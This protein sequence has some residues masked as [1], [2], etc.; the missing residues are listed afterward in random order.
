ML[1]LRD[2]PIEPGDIIFVVHVSSKDPLSLLKRLIQSLIN[3]KQS[4]HGHYEVASVFVCSGKNKYGP[5]CYNHEK[6]L[7]LSSNT[8][9]SKLNLLSVEQLIDILINHWSKK[10][11]PSE[12]IDYLKQSEGWPSSLVNQCES[13]QSSE[14]LMQTLINECGEDKEKIL[15]LLHCF[16]M[17]S[18]YSEIL[19]SVKSSLLVFKPSISIRNQF[20]EKYAY[21]AEITDNYVKKKQSR[22]SIWMVI[23]SIFQ[24]AKQDAIDKSPHPPSEITYCAR[25]VIEVLNQIDPNLVDRGRHVTPKTL[26]AGLREATRPKMAR[27]DSNHDLDDFEAQ[28]AQAQ[29]LIPNFSLVIIPAAGKDLMQ[30]FILKID[31]EI[32]RIENKRRKNSQ[33]IQKLKDIKDIV[34]SYR[35]D[36]YKAYPITLQVT[37]AMELMAKLQPVLQRKTGFLGSWYPAT[38]YQNIRSFLRGQGIFDGDIREAAEHLKTIPAMTNTKLTQTEPKAEN[39]ELAKLTYIFSDWSFTQWSEEKQK[40]MIEYMIQRLDSGCSVLFWEHGQLIAKTKN[41]LLQSFDCEDFD[42]LLSERL[43]P[44]SQ[45][46]ILAQAK[47]QGIKFSSCQF[48]DYRACQNL[49]PSSIPFAQ[50][51]E[52]AAPLF[53]AGYAPNQLHQAKLHILELE[54]ENKDYEEQEK[55]ALLKLKSQLIAQSNQYQKSNYFSGIDTKSAVVQNQKIKPIFTPLNFH[56]FTPSISYYRDEVYT[57]LK[58]NNEPSNPFHYFEL[59]G[60]DLL[61]DLT[62]CNYEFYQAGIVKKDLKTIQSKEKNKVLIKGEKSILLSNDWSSL[63]SLHPNE[64][65]LAVSFKGLKQ[66][67]FE[68]KYSKKSHLYYVRLTKAQDSKNVNLNLVLQMPNH[69]NTYPVLNTLKPNEN[70]PDIHRLLSKYL[71][72]GRDYGALRDSVGNTVHDGEA[73]LNKAKELAVGSCRLRAIAFKEEMLRLHPEVPVSIVVNPRHCYIEMELDGQINRYCLGGYRD[74]PTVLEKVRSRTMDFC[75]RGENRNNFFTPDNHSHQIPAVPLGIRTATVNP[76]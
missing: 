28:I 46:Q 24:S 3:T 68:I 61:V 27:D 35:D 1:P 55:E 11:T 7:K 51:L 52:K 5:I 6:Q 47:K 66:D 58:I 8:Y 57:D 21:Q 65:L 72:F 75:S 49:K 13:I 29:K 20:I 32:T 56:T 25:N 44:A 41:S 62:E 74:S 67:D 71:R 53:T 38:S 30:Q 23:K 48:L 43:R 76:H 33:D 17:G 12:I 16:W 14:L 19:T 45:D 39:P 63:P 73:Y 50:T 15:D 10:C 42:N 4:K 22:S 18:G 9:L 31:K 37:V 34:L 36:K 26:E 2:S 64:T 59:K 54:L 40:F 69:Y 60:M 70:H